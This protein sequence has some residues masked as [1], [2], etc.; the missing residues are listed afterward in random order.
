[1][2]VVQALRDTETQIAE[3]MAGVLDF[4][5]RLQS[6]L[7]QGNWYYAQDKI[8]DLIRS[9]ERL[10]TALNTAL[11]TPHARRK[12]R[13]SHVIAAI[14]QFARHYHAGRVLYP[15]HRDHD[16]AT[17]RWLLERAAHDIQ[18]TPPAGTSVADGERL[19]GILRDY[20]A[21]GRP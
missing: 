20:A 15:M 7:E 21:A 16:V 10:R 14:S 3:C 13:P 5:S 9:A 12:P 2:T 4:L 19:A 8:P 1:M 6:G 11:R 17:T 18:V